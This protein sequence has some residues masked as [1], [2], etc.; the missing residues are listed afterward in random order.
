MAEN[1]QHAQLSEDR[2]IV[3]SCV[4]A[5]IASAI[6]I[7][8]ALLSPGLRTLPL[9]LWLMLVGAFGLVS[10]VKLYERAQF[11]EH[12]ARVLRKKL[13]ELTGD[14]DTIQL[15]SEAQAAHVR[16]HPRLSALRFNSLLSGLNASIILL[17]I[18]YSVLDLVHH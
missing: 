17:G 1:R 12:R 14:T 5:A 15:L 18:L 11:H 4:T 16:Q 8:L 6:T 13:V 10:C 2:R 7:T 3:I 9:A